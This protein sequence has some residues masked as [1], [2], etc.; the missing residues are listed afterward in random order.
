MMRDRVEY[1]EPLGPLGRL[2]NAP[3]VERRLDRIF[4]FRRDTIRRL[5]ESNASLPAL[6]PEER[7]QVSS[8]G[9]A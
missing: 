7:S 8:P 5:F 3:L 6:F 4:D 1:A 9:E 2:A